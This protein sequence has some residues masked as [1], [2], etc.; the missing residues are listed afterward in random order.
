MKVV[1]S[2]I[3][4]T[5]QEFANVKFGVE[6]KGKQV[7]EQLSGLGFAD[8]LKLIDA[9]KNEDTETFSNLITFFSKLPI[10]VDSCEEQN[11]HAELHTLS[12][13]PPTTR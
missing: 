13:T 7:G 1:N 6:L 3:V 4:D 5:V 8:T 9:I 12:R 10:V 11:W 2:S